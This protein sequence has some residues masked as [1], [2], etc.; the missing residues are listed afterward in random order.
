MEEVVGQVKWTITNHTK[1]HSSSKEGDVL[2]IMG[3]E[4]SSLLWAPSGKPEN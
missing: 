4:D 2:Y 1:G 3:L